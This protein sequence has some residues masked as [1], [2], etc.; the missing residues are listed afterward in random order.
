M[1]RI[2]TYPLDTDIKGADKIIGTDATTNNTKNFS[3]TGVKNFVGFREEVI[4]VTTAELQGIGTT[5]KTIVTTGANEIVDIFGV[6]FKCSGNTSADQLSFS[7]NLVLAQEG[8]T[9]TSGEV[10]WALPSSQ[11]SLFTTNYYVPQRGYG[12]KTP[13]LDLV[14]TS[15]NSPIGTGSPAMELKIYIA[16]RLVDVA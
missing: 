11:A 6:I 9:V 16:Y 8:A 13:G 5:E 15:N 2:R 1:A 4:T 14:L 3:L 12:S 10:Q 7:H